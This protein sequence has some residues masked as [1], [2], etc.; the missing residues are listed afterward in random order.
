MSN[1]ADNSCLFCK[2]V[3]GTIP[4]QI[5]FND[6]DML[7]F[8]DIHPQAPVHI[9]IIP[10]KHISGIGEVMDADTVL[11]G[12]LAVVARTL[13]EKE[14]L[15]SGYRLVVNN[16]PD[17]GQAVAHLHFHLLGGRMF[18]WPPG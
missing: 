4:A 18:S 6:D 13:A 14:K 9:L 10:K 3:A 11:L 7:A 1:K 15:S 17:A 5:V 2:I 8:R 12:K 16:G